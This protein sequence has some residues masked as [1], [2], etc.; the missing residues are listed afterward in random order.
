VPVERP[1]DPIGVDWRGALQTGT[2]RVQLLGPGGDVIWQEEAGS[3]GGFSINTVVEAPTSGDHQLQLAWDGPARA[4]YTLTWQPGPVEIGQ[5]TPIALLGGLG[6]LAVGAGCIVYSAVRRL[7]WG[8]LGLGA[9]AWLLTVA[10]KSAWAIAANT[11]IYSGLQGALPASLADLVFYLY[12]GALTG[13][14]EVLLLWL[15]MRYTRLGQMSWSLALAFGLGF[16]AA[17]ALA[18]GAQSLATVLVA[19]LVP[20][21]VPLGPDMIA[22]LNNPLYTIAPGVERF[23]AVLL[24]VFAN[25]LIIYGARRHQA[26]WFWLA[27]AYKTGIDAVA[28]FAQ[29]QGL[30]T[31]PELWAIEAVVAVW[32]IAGWL[33]IRW[34]RPRWDEQPGGDL[35]DAA[36][37]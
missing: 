16:G 2:V 25:L 13:I 3:P 20:A 24:H 18:L 8:Y 37:P 1:G 26:R 35:A 5:V 4:S 28:A 14:F 32:G 31:F 33:G 17:E 12:V 11:T 23:F 6:M 22:Q 9:L 30:T 7:G 36:T 27:F 19:M 10:L 15:V 21:V 29:I 34:L